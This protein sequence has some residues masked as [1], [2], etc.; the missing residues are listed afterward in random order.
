[1]GDSC[2]FF[3]ATKESAFTHAIIA[4]GIT[5][6]VTKACS[7]NE[8]GGCGCATNNNKLPESEDGISWDRCNDNAIFG[9]NVSAQFLKTMEGGSQDLHT[10]VNLHNNKAGRLVREV[11]E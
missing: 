5:H 2:L 1:M 6:S 10:I 8:I 9:A 7:R 3:T 11:C 4:A